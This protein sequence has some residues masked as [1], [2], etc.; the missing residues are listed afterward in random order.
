[1]NLPPTVVE[2]WRRR[3]LWDRYEEERHRLIGSILQEQRELAVQAVR[4]Y[5]RQHKQRL[6]IADLG[7]GTGRI[8]CDLL[9]LEETE[10]LVAVDVNPQA[11]QRTRQHAREQKLEGKLRTLEG[12]FYQLNWGPD[13]SFDVILCMDALHHLPDVPTMLRII[14]GRLRPEGI[15]VGNFR[16]AASAPLF[17]GR[18]GIIKRWLIG[19]QPALDRT[20]SADSR[21]RQWLGSI[22]YFRIR[23]FERQEVERLLLDADYRILALEE[24]A[25][26]WFC[27]SRDDRREADPPPL[28]EYCAPSPQDVT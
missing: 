4:E 10:L 28:S 9:A 2:Y 16:S 21:L 11:L 23:T 24:G 6:R 25:Y 18:Y 19:I 15:F 8:A 5:A 3:R 17:F 22:G 14:R 1:M 20:L 27:A 26:Y 13:A 7:C 12:D